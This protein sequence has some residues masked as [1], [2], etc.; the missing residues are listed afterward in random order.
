MKTIDYVTVGKMMDTITPP[1]VVDAMHGKKHVILIGCD[2]NRNPD[3]LQVKIIESHFEGLKPQIA[4][5]EGGQVADSVHFDS[6][7]ES[8]AKTGETGCLK[9]LSDKY[10]IKMMDGD[11]SDSLEFK[12]MLRKTAKDKLFL[13]YVMERVVI[14]YLSGAYGNVPFDALYQKAIKSWFIKPGF[15][16]KANEQ[17]LGYFKQLYQKHTGHVFVLK[18]SDDIE[19]FDYINPDCQFCE[20]G[21]TSKMT[22]DS[23]LLSK[24]SASLKKFDRVIVTFGYGHAIALKPAIHQLVAGE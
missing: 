22:R 13:Y 18:F 17:T 15:P 21:R 11:M 7:R 8:V 10:H 6:L 14:P 1:Y 24:I 4:F 19:R 20:I 23:V 16:L 12:L 3:H 5:N 9:F 2:H